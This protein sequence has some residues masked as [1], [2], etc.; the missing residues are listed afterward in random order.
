[1]DAT[2]QVSN[3]LSYQRY[4]DGFLPIEAYGAIGNGKTVALVGSDGSLDW[5]C[6]PRI[7]SPSIFG[8]LLNGGTAGFWQIVPTGN[9]KVK[10]EYR[11]DSNVLVTTFVTET[12]S[13][14][15]TDFMPSIGMGGALGIVDRLQGGVLIRIVR[16]VQGTVN[17]QQHIVPG[18]DYGRDR[19]TFEMVPGRGALIRGSAQYLSIHTSAKLEPQDDRLSGTF[20]VS[21]G[22]E[23]PIIATYHG[24]AAPV[25]MEFAPDTAARLRDSEL[26]LWKIWINRCTYSGPYASEL[27]RSALALKLLDYLPSGA[28]A[29]AATTSL[30][31]FPGGVRNWD[32]RYAWIRDTTYALYSYMS[33]GYQ[34]EAESFFQWIIDATDLNPASLQIMYRVDGGR[35]LEEFSLDHFGGYRGSRPVRIGNDAYRQKQLDVWGEILDAALI[36]RRFGGVISEALW[37]YLMAIVT[38]V[39][40]HWQDT[41]SGIWEVRSEPTRM[42][43]S[44]VMCWLALDRAIKLAKIDNRTAPLAEWNHVAGMIRNDVMSRGVSPL[45]GTFVQ[46]FD[47]H[48]LDASALSFAL[49]H[50][51]DVHHPVMNRTIDAIQRELTREGL[52]RRYKVDDNGE[53]VDGIQGEEGHFVLTSCWLIDSLIARGE[54]DKAREMLEQLLARSND[55]GLFAEQIDPVTGEHLGNF[56]QAFSHLGIINSIL[57]I[58]RATGAADIPATAEQLLL[59]ADDSFVAE[60]GVQLQGSGVQKTD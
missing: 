9:W 2:G 55:L 23:I 59:H 6:L 56:P 33:I 58:A 30:P 14:E 3:F 54:I 24:S 27:R 38:Q 48:V 12:G 21:A 50:F 36:Y 52:V 26:E 37:D 17:L 41:D 1:M 4:D 29:A 40:L 13:V 43:Y 45:T 32:Y 46:S 47:S 16:G 10:R 42:T 31:E 51:I 15:L 35:D 39:L 7:D 8:R 34:E 18:F 25:W 20:D 28:M 22:D 44:N 60:P 5:L 19:P 49:R 11:A 53:N 57:N